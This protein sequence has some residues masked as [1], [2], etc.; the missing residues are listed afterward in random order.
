VTQLLDSTVAIVALAGL[1]WVAIATIVFAACKAAA[2]ADAEMTVQDDAVAMAGPMG[3]L[4]SQS[5]PG[6]HVTYGAQEDLHVPPQ[7]PVGDV[8]VIHRAHLA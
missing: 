3:W 1:A 2:R 5:S 7:R 6:E 4:L 8:Q